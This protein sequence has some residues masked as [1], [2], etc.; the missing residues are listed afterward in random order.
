MLERE[1]FLNGR[2]LFQRWLRQGS[3]LISMVIVFAVF[4]ILAPIFISRQNL[5]NVALQASINAV[6]SL[7]MTLVIITAGIDLSVGSI[8][9]LTS[10]M[11]ALSMVNGVSIWLSI[12]LTLALGLLCGL[13]NGVLVSYVKLQPF[14]VTLGTMSLF[15]GLAL[16]FSNGVPIYNLPKSFKSVIGLATVFSIP[17]PVIIMIVFSLLVFVVLRHTKLGEYIFA[18]GGNEEATRLSGVNVRK[19]KA[20]TYGLSGIASTLGAIILIGRLGAA[21][22]VAGT[23]YELDAIAA[24]AIGGASLAGGRGSIFGTIVGA[25]ILSALRNGLTLLNV[26]SFYQMVATGAIIIIAIIID[27][28]SHGKQE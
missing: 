8:V 1:A 22:A 24:A 9:A 12:V 19:N 13:F 7:G 20:I 6:V 5:I 27:R 17:V 21:E 26:P 18:I 10:V 28:L 23:G 11:A 25:I 3:I 2:A 15:R 14:L 16:I 4:T